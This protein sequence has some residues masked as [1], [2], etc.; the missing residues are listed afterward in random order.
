[1][2]LPEPGQA[3]H[4]DRGRLLGWRYTRFDGKADVRGLDGLPKGYSGPLTDT[5]RDLGGNRIGV[6]DILEKLD[7]GRPVPK[8]RIARLGAPR[9]TPLNRARPCLHLAKR[10]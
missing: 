9:A 2:G 1:M 7:G 3:I 5:T 8:V 4:D 6:G 10:R